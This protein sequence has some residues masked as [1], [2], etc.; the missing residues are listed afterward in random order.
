[1]NTEPN[2]EGRPVNDQVNKQSTEGRKL[3]GSSERWVDTSRRALI[4]GNFSKD[5]PVPLLISDSRTSV[6]SLSELA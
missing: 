2:G 1:M 5:H 3:V 6:Y 4:S